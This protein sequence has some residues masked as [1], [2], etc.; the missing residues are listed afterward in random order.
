MKHN[1]RAAA[2]LAAEKLATLAAMVCLMLALMNVEAVANAQSVGEALARIGVQAVLLLAACIPASLA[3]DVHDARLRAT[4]A[5]NAQ[6]EKGR[7]S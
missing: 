3:I 7:K 5:K 1:H 2:L 4:R 6:V